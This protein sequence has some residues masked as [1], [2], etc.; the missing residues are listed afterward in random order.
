MS[1]PHDP[2]LWLEDVEGEDALAWVHEQ[3]ART[4]AALGGADGFTE[5]QR[6]LLAVLDSDEKI[7][8]VGQA[9]DHLYNFWQDAGHER[10]IWRRTTWDSY[11]ADEPAW[12]TVLDVDALA[13]AEGV[14]WAWGGAT[15]LPPEHRLCM[16]RLSRG[17]ADAVEIRE[18]DLAAKAFVEGGFRLPEA[19]AEVAWRGPDELLV[20]SAYGDDATTT[21]GYARHARLWR[22]GTPLAE[23]RVL[24][25]AAPADVA[26][27]VGSV[28]TPAG[29]VHLVTHMPGFFD[30]VGT[31][32]YEAWSRLKGTP[33]DVAQQQYIELV[34]KL[35]G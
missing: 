29:A 19:K 3:N 14:P 24:L 6:D 1:T 5:L 35:K 8:F 4:D 28:E 18:F 11:L 13:A 32:K 31:A 16:V 26:V 17:G 15:S 22:R 10:G 20:A 25:E 21:S 9:G 34:A 7:P 12:E 33:R 2:H 30:F 23:A 27:G